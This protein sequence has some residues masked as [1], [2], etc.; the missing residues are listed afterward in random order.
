MNTKHESL[1]TVANNFE[2]K[3]ETMHCQ[4]KAD[5]TIPMRVEELEAMRL[6]GP[7]LSA[8]KHSLEDIC[9]IGS[10]IGSM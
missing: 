2:L 3:N 1:I 4:K 9:G 7:S 5:L 10:G 6:D 8:S